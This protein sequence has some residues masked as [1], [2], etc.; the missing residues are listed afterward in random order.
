MCASVFSARDRPAARGET[1]SHIA[2]YSKHD[3]KPAVSRQLDCLLV[4]CP[5]AANRMCRIPTGAPSRKPSMTFYDEYLPV[6]FY[7]MVEV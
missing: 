4:R 2:W 3:T 6:K 5:Q 7:V 1:D